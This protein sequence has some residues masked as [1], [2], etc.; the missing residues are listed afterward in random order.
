M[1]DRDDSQRLTEAIAAASA[2]RRAIA[3]GG[4]GSKSFLARADAGALLSVTDHVG[5]VEYRPDELVITARAGTSLKDVTTVLAGAGQVLPFD[6][7]RFAGSGTVGGA[8]AAGL[9]GPGRPWHGAFRDAVLGVEV[10]NGL[11]ERLNFGGQ[12]LKNVAGYDV[13]RLMVGS[14]GTLGLI[15]QVSVRVQP[16]PETVLTLATTCTCDDAV[17][18]VRT[19]ISRALPI[20]AT[21]Y[22]GGVLRVRLSGS[23]E[24]V[25]HARGELAVLDVEADD[26]AF[27]A[28]VR[29]HNHP[30]FTR[31]DAPLWLVSIP[32]GSFFEETDAL[33]EW[34]GARAWWRTEADPE[35]VHAKARS[36]GGYAAPFSHGL[37]VVS[38]AVKKYMRRVKAAFD[39]QGILN[40]GVM[41]DA[42]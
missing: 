15:L 21:C 31:R 5:V 17:G 8:A 13:S 29:D 1:A 23:G 3:I 18:L 22:V 11:G 35:F 24:S 12:V 41:I 37:P 7:P 10:V 32:R 20:T 26:D 28:R 39:P 40:P 4:S 25:R 33:I 16:A 30:F 34:A 6:P 42:N 19:F 9:S 38:D 27:F 36:L 2:S 14:F